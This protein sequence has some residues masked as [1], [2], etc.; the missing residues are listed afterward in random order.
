MRSEETARC[1]LPRSGTIGFSEQ[2]SADGAQIQSPDFM[3]INDS[4]N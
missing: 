2:C 4:S 3:N 1:P